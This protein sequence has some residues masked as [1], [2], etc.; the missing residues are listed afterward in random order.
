MVL[1][2]STAFAVC[3]IVDSGEEEVKKIKGSTKEENEK[4]FNCP[5]CD[6]QQGVDMKNLIG[7]G[8]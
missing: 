5:F 6:Q 8:I 7:K 1:L 2:L 3:R 4:V